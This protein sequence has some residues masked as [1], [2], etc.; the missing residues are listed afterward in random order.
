MHRMRA[1]TLV[2]L[3]ACGARGGVAA[4]PPAAHRLA[5][6]TTITTPSGAKLVVARG[7]WLTE[8]GGLVLIEDPDRQLRTWF[9]ES[10]ERDGAAAIAAGWRRV[11]PGFALSL[12]R[13]PERPPPAGGWDA[14]TSTEYDAGPDRVVQ[15]L[16]R[17]LGRVTF[18]VLVDGQRA[19][20][21][22]RGAQLAHAIESLHPP[23]LRAESLAGIAP[24][25]L[26]R[27]AA[28]RLD[29]FIERAMTKLAVPGAA[30]AVVQ[31]GRVVY[32]RG[33]GVRALGKGEPVTAR[34]LFMIGSI[35]K[36]MTTMM[37]A[38]QVDAGL[39]TWDTPV[40]RVLPS[41]ALADAALTGAIVM[42]H[43]SCACTGMPR[44]DLDH[45]FE[46]RG[47]TAEQRVASMRSMAPTTRLGETF[48]YSNLMV[49]A[50]GYV[51]AHADAPRRPLGE[52]YD[53][54]MRRR[55]FAPIGM[56]STT[57]DFAAALA[58]EHAMPHGR[59]IDGAVRPV[60]LAMEENVV[61]IR[62]AGGVWSNLRD[63]ERFVMTELAGGAAPDGT[64]VVSQVNLTARRTVRIGTAEDGYGLGLGVGRIL[65]LPFL[66][67][68]GGAFGFG[69][70]MFMLPE[71]RI[72]IVVLSNIR[73]D[74]P[75]EYLPFN[76]VVK[77]AV[78]EA[79]FPG[80]RDLA[81]PTLDHFAHLAREAAAR[82]GAQLRRP[83]D[84]AWLRSLAGRYTNP[85]LGEVAVT[86]SAEGAAAA[87]ATFDTGEWQRA[88]GEGRGAGGER[89]LVFLEPPF[90][91]SAI[92]V[93]G[94]AA[95]P[96]LTIT[97]G[98]ETFVFTRR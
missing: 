24:R 40:T 82:G 6:D 54:A 5:V 65:G 80:A 83:A 98:Q 69:S 96:T 20:A 93:G 19:A 18:V 92:A 34:T 78:L 9:L 68:D 16:A 21:A 41:F 11:A 48:Q 43:M 62:P 86:A 51:A 55:V 71:Q 26:D 75:G 37:E 77:R 66:E 39:F 13:E 35:T 22:R 57:L 60:P 1:A 94:D 88:L 25:P 56:T 76:A 30:V 64:R 53:D 87:T 32:E 8:R 44:S 15:A 52:A 3:A 17:R 2:V 33:F 91:G 10:R 89:T 90:A 36:S 4:P 61:T 85:R 27:G 81:V 97:D 58:G 47:V 46:Y 42:W 14:V 79:L 45:I 50:G 70:T 95:H 23:D 67:H 28:A 49:A 73:N 74:V 72:A 12:A 59:D 63:M 29:A 84:G 31:D 7:W 38:A